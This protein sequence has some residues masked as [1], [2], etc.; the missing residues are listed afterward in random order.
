[1]LIGILQLIEDAD[2]PQAII[3]R[4]LDAVPSGSRLAIAHPAGDVV[5]EVVTMARHLSR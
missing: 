3:G 1:M 4:L 2:A 5:P